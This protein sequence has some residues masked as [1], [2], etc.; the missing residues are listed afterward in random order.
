MRASDDR[1]RHTTTRRELVRLDSGALLIDTP[2]MRELGLWDAS[3]GVSQ[4]FADIEELALGCRFRDCAH[5]AE[6]GCAVQA[7]LIE[8]SLA[9]ERLASYRKLQ[10]ELAFQTRRTDLQARLAEQARWKQLHKQARQPI[11]EKGR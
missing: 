2:G 8:G 5:G 9:P 1:G 11:N 7:A 3:D 10:R 6:T 4:T